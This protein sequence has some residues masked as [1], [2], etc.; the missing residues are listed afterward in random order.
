VRR[1]RVD[2]HGGAP[3]RRAHRAHRRYDRLPT[4]N[5]DQPHDQEDDHHD[6]V[7]QH[8]ALE[9]LLELSPQRRLLELRSGLLWL[10]GIL[11]GVGLILRRRLG[12]R[13][14]LKRVRLRLGLGQLWRWQRR[15]RPRLVLLQ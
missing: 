10:V 14:R 5:H 12:L 9:R 4:S 11:L 15:R 7:V 13:R 8:R 6:L 2:R 3:E 1:W